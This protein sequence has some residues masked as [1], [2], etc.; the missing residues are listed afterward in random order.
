MTI[1]VY[2]SSIC[3][4][5][6]TT[7]LEITASPSTSILDDQINNDN[8][9]I[10]PVPAKDYLKIKGINNSRIAIY[11]TEGRLVKAINNYTE[12]SAIQVSDLKTGIYYI[13]IIYNGKSYT[14]AINVKN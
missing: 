6:D 1:K 14:K 13:Q 12:E 8:V 7:F 10:Y 4:E 11:N 3:G 9:I 2:A 5:S